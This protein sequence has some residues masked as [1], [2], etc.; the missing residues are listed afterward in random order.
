MSSDIQIEQTIQQ[1]G[2]TA[3]R[4][5]LA[6]LEANIAD[7][8]YVKHVSKGGGILR[9]AVI[10]TQNGFSVTGRPSAAVSVKN[11]N[12]EIGEKVAYENAK[13]ELW[14]LMGYALKEKISSTTED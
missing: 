3:P 11:D 10:T 9:W 2:L 1:K 5:S 8:E 13:S 12:Q 4:V 6:D 7:V 14:P